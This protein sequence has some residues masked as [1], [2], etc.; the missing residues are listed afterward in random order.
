MGKNLEPRAAGIPNRAEEMGTVVPSTFL[1]IS[2]F[3]ATFEEAPVRA[4]ARSTWAAT[5]FEQEAPPPVTV[6]RSD[7]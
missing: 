1:F 2:A 3:T 5:G 7:V 6:L 4:A